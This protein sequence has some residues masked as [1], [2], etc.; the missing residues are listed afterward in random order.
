MEGM[1][2]KGGEVNMK[3]GFYSEVGEKVGGVRGVIDG[4]MVDGERKYVGGWVMIGGFS[5]DGCGG[6]K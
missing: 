1:G 4:K 6:E 3:E 2:F 5:E